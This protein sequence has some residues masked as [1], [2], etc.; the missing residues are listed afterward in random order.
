MNNHTILPGTGTI[1]ILGGGQLGRMSAM[2]AKRLGYKVV[3]FSD[4]ANSP[5]GQVSDREIVGDYTDEHLLQQ[6]SSEVDVVTYEF[7]NIPLQAIQNLEANGATV[8]PNSN[9]I[10][11]SQNRIAERRLL[12][13][14]Q[15]PTAPFAILQKEMPQTLDMKMPAIIKTAESGYDGKGQR[16]INSLQELHEA[17]HEFGGVDCII[18]ERISFVKEFSIILARSCTGETRHYGP[19]ENIHKNHILN[20]SMYPAEIPKKSAEDAISAA[21]TVAHSLNFIG[22]LAVE[23]FLQTDGTVLVNELAPRPHN[24]GHLTIEGFVTSQF[25]QHIRSVC[26]LPLGSVECTAPSIMIN[27]LGD[28]WKN[29]TPPFERILN[30][31]NTNLHLYGK[32]TPRPGRK[33]GHITISLPSLNEARTT[34]KTIEGILLCE[35]ACEDV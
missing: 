12:S 10:A 24:S 21:Q 11:A 32:P 4:V 13:N 2:V 29:G 8:R 7:E 19:I 5:A 34:A 18:E 25:E 31:P 33:M 28:L 35:R 16:S 27:L 17:W 1:G 3:I 30:H 14:L 26:G 23:F 22:V 15:I 20:R 6:F 9:S